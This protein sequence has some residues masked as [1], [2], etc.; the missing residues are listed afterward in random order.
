[1]IL[2]N[3]FK[4][5]LEKRLAIRYELFCWLKRKEKEY[6]I[7]QIVPRDFNTIPLYRNAT[8]SFINECYLATILA[9]GSAIEQ[10]LLWQ[11][12]KNLN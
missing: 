1:M 7:E 3:E 8:F 11:K 9:I 2:F 5:S 10:F 6:D 4:S 12:Q